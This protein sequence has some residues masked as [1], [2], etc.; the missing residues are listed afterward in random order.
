MLIDEKNCAGGGIPRLA[1]INDMAGFGRCSTAVSLP[2]ISVMGVQVCPVPTSILSNHLGFPRCCAVDFTPRMRDYI[3]TWKELELSFDGLYCGF[4]GEPKQAAIVEEF[5]DMFR[6]PI[7]LLDPVMADHGRL[8]SSVTEEHCQRLKKL[9]ARAHILTPN[10]TEA[11]LLTDTPYR[12]EGWE[13]DELDLL[14]RKLSSLC[15]GAIVIT[16]LQENGQFR[17]IIW[18]KGKKEACSAPRAGAS[19]PGTGDL[20]ASILAAD[21]LLGRNLRSSVQKASDFIA[22][23]VRNSEQAGIPIRE[24][25]GFEP[26]LGWLCANHSVNSNNSPSSPI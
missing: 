24:G 6:P 17:N 25:V 22:L 15:P 18:E 19:R 3:G 20:F 21:A 9:A 1:M 26:L 10:L 13:E 23:C 14:C 7:F 11:C 16:G 12:E 5:L 4:L 8:Y 2:V